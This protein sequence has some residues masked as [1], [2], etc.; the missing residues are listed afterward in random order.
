MKRDLPDPYV[1][2]DGTYA[3]VHQLILMAKFYGRAKRR[4]KWAT[5]RAKCRALWGI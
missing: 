4:T 3:T 1:G 5:F 2:C